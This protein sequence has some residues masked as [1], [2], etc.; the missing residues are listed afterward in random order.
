MNVSKV[1]AATLGIMCIVLVVGVVWT[2]T[3]YTS[4]I[5]DR[6]TTISNKDVQIS[7]LQ[8]QKNQVQTWLDA[9]KTE[10]Q[11]YVANHQHTDQDFGA[12]QSIYNDYVSSH[13]HS[14]TEYDSLQS[15]ANLEQQ[16]TV[17][18]QYTISTGANTH[19]LVTSFQANYA[20]FLYISLTSTTTNAYVIVE[21]WYQ[22]RLFSVQ[23]TLG[24]SGDAYFCL[25]PA[26]VA[27]Y[28]GN[29]HYT[30]V[31][32]TMTAIYYY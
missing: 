6:N 29:T 3:Y 17:L 5:N 1:A 11:N 21:Y 9:N 32:Y 7:D 25:L 23:R 10:Y 16:Q 19:A 20:G 14:N 22:G 28:V 15:I 13:Q 18:N 26:S 4:V 24:T 12:L 2:Y 8:S 31:T 30:G 27:V